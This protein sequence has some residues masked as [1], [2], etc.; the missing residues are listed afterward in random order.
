MNSSDMVA[1]GDNKNESTTGSGL[2]VLDS[3]EMESRY[4]AHETDPNQIVTLIFFR[5]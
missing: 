1:G 5:L 4:P 3:G 2:D